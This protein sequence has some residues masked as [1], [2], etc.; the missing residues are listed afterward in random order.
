M[1]KIKFPQSFTYDGQLLELHENET[2]GWVI[3]L[4]DPNSVDIYWTNHYLYKV[5]KLYMDSGIQITFQE[6]LDRI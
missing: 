2:F 5:A 1:S 4:A 6:F 3:I